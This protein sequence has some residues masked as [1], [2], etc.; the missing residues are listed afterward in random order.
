MNPRA[1]ATATAVV[2]VTQAVGWTEYY[3]LKHDRD[4]YGRL[5]LSSLVFA[6]LIGGITAA[7]AARG[8]QSRGRRRRTGL[9][10]LGAAGGALMALVT[11]I[12]VGVNVSCVN[13]NGDECGFGMVVEMLGDGLLVALFGVVG[14]TMLILGRDA[15]GE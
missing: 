5:A 6:P 2:L 10:L 8:V 14:A 4:G 12:V 13:V 11:V 3:A 7:V 15:R 1:P 9:V